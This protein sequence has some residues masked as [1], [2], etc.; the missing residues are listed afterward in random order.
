MVADTFGSFAQLVLLVLGG[1]LISRGKDLLPHRCSDDLSVPIW[2]HQPVL[3]CSSPS[4][5][6][7]SRNGGFG[8]TGHRLL[9]MLRMPSQ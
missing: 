3:T 5:Q 4:S 8:A 7:I 9:C 6:I 2:Q 1:F